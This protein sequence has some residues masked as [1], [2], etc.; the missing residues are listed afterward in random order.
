MINLWSTNRKLRSKGS[1]YIKPG[2]VSFN[3]T[4]CLSFIVLSDTCS[5]IVVEIM[6]QVRSD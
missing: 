5:L 4:E 6:I 2:D 3:L 1:W